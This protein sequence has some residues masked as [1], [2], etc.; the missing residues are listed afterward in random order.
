MS[1]TERKGKTEATFSNGN[2]QTADDTY[3]DSQFIA[4]NYSNSVNPILFDV[5]PDIN[6]NKIHS[7][8]E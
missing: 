8:L 2:E 1:K 3:K 5:D 4:E 6:E 7:K